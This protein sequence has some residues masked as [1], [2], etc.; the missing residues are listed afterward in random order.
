MTGVETFTQQ[1]FGALDVGR[2]WR[3]FGWVGMW[4]VREPRVDSVCARWEL[5]LPSITKKDGAVPLEGS[6]KRER[7]YGVWNG[8]IGRDSFVVEG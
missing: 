2:L 7:R 8:R 4:D 6:I 5:R 1:R 3:T